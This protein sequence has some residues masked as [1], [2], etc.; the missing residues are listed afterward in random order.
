MAG[1]WELADIK[2]KRKK[3]LA[4]GVSF[5]AHVQ[6]IIPSRDYYA[7]RRMRCV[8]KRGKSMQNTSAD[9]IEGRGT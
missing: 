5:G 1:T 3:V 6:V 8:E 2:E 4:Y 9:E 7:I